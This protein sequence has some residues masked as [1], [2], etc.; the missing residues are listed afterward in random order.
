[1]T[2]STDTGLE[3][4]A[5]L[6]VMDAIRQRRSVRHYRSDPI[7]EA[8]L[9]E[10]LEALRLAPSGCNAQPWRF[11]VVREEA[12][13]AR[14]AEACAF[15]WRRTGDVGIQRWIADAPVVVVACGF[16]AQA[17]AIYLRGGEAV[18]AFDSEGAEEARRLGA[19]YQS[20]LD[21]DLAIALDHLS[22]A[23]AAVGLGT[24]WIGG[25][26]E[27]KLKEA[28]G[29]PADVRAPLAMTLGYPAEWPDPRPRKQLSEIVCYD[30]YG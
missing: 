1:M 28:L 16:E 21:N 14:V 18:I 2:N 29:I 15:A 11:V 4:A 5:S 8:V 22:L 19:R 12:T 17:G 23:A 10:L 26:N 13:K 9:L 24:C 3:T 20:S 30:R 25:L 7:P 6:R 27:P